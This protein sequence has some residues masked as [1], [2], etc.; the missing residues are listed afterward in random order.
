M[1][2]M[3]KYC[4]DCDIKGYCDKI[5]AECSLAKENKRISDFEEAKA[6][7]IKGLENIVENIFNKLDVIIKKIRR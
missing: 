1:V 6:E 4:E 3:S 5:P 7:V 2:N